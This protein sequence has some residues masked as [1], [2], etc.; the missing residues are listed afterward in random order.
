M[1]RSER[2][3]NRLDD[4]IED[5]QKKGNKTISGAEVFD[6]YETHGFPRELTR[7]LLTE[8]V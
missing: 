3:V 7:E 6:L 8:P 5:A 2:G 4:L 1:K